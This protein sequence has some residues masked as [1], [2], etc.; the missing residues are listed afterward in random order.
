MSSCFKGAGQ[1]EE[2]RE[3][4]QEKGNPL[5]G[6]VLPNWLRFHQNAAKCS[7]V[8]HPGEASERRNR[9]GW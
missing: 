7:A 1:W 9:T 2:K 3:M 6:G 8:S 4:G 5:R